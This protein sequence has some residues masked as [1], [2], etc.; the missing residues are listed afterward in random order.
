MLTRRA[1]RPMVKTFAA[2]GSESPW[3]GREHEAEAAVGLTRACDATSA[4]R[5]ATSAETAPT[6]STGT[7]GLRARGT[8][9]APEDAM[10]AMEAMEAAVDLPET[11]DTEAGQ[12]EDTEHHSELHAL[13]I[14]K[15]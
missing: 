14:L 15:I 9:A 5:E 1:G 8:G 12:E 4:A 11:G 6:P 10:E 3:Q 13:E 7:S 2:G